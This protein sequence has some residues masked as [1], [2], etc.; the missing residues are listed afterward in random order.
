MP[1]ILIITY[2]G[3]DDSELIY[4]L[5]R[6]LEEGFLVD[7]CSMEKRI[8]KAK[9]HF[10]IEATLLPTEI[11]VKD[12]DGLYLPGGMA[13]E[14]L[15]QNDDVLSVVKEFN[16]LNKPIVAICHG[17]QL[18]ISSDILRGVSATCYPGIKADLI[19]AGAKY[20]DQ[21]VVVDKNIITSRRPNDMPFMMKKFIE[22]VK[23]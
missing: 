4:P 10:S 14:K 2:D 20:I 23:N 22:I 21:S 13:P 3:V 1:K 19:N 15:R 18:L 8:I 17:P 6:M 5:F 7:V 9:Y 11:K 12:Y 16:S